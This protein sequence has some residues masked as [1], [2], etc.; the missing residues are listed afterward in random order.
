MG[1]LALLFAVVGS[2]ET[3]IDGICVCQRLGPKGELC[4]SPPLQLGSNF[5]LCDPEIILL[6][7]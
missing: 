1:G 5:A 7:S 3:I 2:I 6:L 4:H